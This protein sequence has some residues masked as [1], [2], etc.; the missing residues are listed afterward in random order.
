MSRRNFDKWLYLSAD[1]NS[2]LPK[3]TQLLCP[4][5]GKDSIDFQYV[6]DVD[7]KVGYLD[8]WCN[9]CLNG[10]NISRTILPENA[11]ILSY[12]TPKEEITRRIP[13]FKHVTP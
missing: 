13:N 8:V 6:G 3:E 4:I 11:N 1:I 9:E 12:S 5:C 7:A 2:S 10:I